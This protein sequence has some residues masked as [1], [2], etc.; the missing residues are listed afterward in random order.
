MA[1]AQDIDELEYAL[2]VAVHAI[3]PALVKNQF[4]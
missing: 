1:G 2:A 4:L 3:G